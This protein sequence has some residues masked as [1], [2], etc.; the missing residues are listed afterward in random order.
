MYNSVLQRK[1][2]RRIGVC[3]AIDRIRQNS[4]R[5]FFIISVIRSEEE[6]PMFAF[7]R[8]FTEIAQKLAYIIKFCIFSFELQLTY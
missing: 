8:L 3:A 2:E 4:E 1:T 5:F 7:S 6:R